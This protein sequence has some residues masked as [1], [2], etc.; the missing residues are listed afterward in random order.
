[1]ERKRDTHVGYIMKV[2]VIN[3]YEY[4]TKEWNGDESS[5]LDVRIDLELGWCCKV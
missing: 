3:N 2:G 5:G 1:V 4:V